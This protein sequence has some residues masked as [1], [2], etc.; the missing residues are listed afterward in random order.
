M[1]GVG[2]SRNEGYVRKFLGMSGVRF[3]GAVSRRELIQEQMRAVVQA[4]PCTYDELFCY[5]VAE[6]KIAGAYPVTPPTGALR[7]TNMGKLIEGNPHDPR[8]V[9]TFVESVVGELKDPKLIEKQLEVQIKAQGRFSIEKIS[10][11]WE[12]VFNE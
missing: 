3:L 5:S 10:N 1:W 11:E 2:N 9:E 7:T 4:Y 8:W 12:K 6:C